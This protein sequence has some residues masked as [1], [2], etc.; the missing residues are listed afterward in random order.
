MAR[1]QANIDEVAASQDRFRAW[2]KR[3]QQEL[4]HISTAAAICVPKSAEG[5]ATGTSYGAVLARCGVEQTAGA[6]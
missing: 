2:Q 3:K 4:Q 1:I 6:R 5:G